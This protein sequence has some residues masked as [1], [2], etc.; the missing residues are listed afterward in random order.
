MEEEV[1]E[2]ARSRGWWGGSEVRLQKNPSVKSANSLPLQRP[3]GAP[4]ILENKYTSDLGKTSEN[5]FTYSLI[6][7]KMNVKRNQLNIPAPHWNWH[8]RPA[9]EQ[10][11][12]ADG[13]FLS[14]GP[15]EVRGGGHLPGYVSV[16]SKKEE[17]RDT[18]SESDKSVRQHI[19][20]V[21]EKELSPVWFWDEHDNMF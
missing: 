5:L 12:E 9:E 7:L 21:G 2:V 15:Q 1:R 18:W 19:Y 4:F 17:R 20:T 3:S 11:R 14:S 10:E 6:C 8:Q 13:F 16:T